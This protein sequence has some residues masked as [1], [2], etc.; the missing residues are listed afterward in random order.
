MN[1][2]DQEKRLTWIELDVFSFPR[3]MSN[4]NY[5]DLPFSFADQHLERCVGASPTQH[6]HARVYFFEMKS[7][8]LNLFLLFSLLAAISAKPEP[9]KYKRIPVSQITQKACRGD[10]YEAYALTDKVCPR[11]EMNFFLTFLVG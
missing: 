5:F 1:R 4:V 2:M 11:R 7:L 3:K 10:L 9:R 8:R 6:F